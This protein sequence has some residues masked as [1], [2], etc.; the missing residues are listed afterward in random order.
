[1]PV[2]LE[3]DPR[4]T[5][6]QIA[7]Q[8]I[9]EKRRQPRTAEPDFAVPRIELQSEGGLNEGKRRGAGPGLRCARDRVERRSGTALPLEPAKQLPQPVQVHMKEASNSP[10][11][12]GSTDGLKP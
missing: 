10:L 1:M 8:H 9:V 7:Q 11:N 2:D 5:E 6:L 3:V 4:L 12:T